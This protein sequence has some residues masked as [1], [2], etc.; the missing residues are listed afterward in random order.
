MAERRW[1]TAALVAMGLVILLLMVALLLRLSLVYETFAVFV[2]KLSSGLG[3]DENL[4]TAIAALTVVPFIYCVGVAFSFRA[5][6]RMLGMFGVAAYVAAYSLAAWFVSQ[7]VYFGPDGALKYYA[8]T[9]EGLYFSDEP[10]VDPV[11][12][13]RLRPVTREVVAASRTGAKPAAL[14]SLDRVEHFFDPSTGEP[15]VWYAKYA[16][17]DVKLFS[18]PGFD[19]KTGLPLLPITPEIIERQRRR[20]AERSRSEAEDRSTAA[21]ENLAKA[22]ARTLQQMVRDIAVDGSRRTVGFALSL[23]DAKAVEGQAPLVCS[24]A[25]R[26]GAPSGVDP[27]HD[28]FAPE[29]IANGY[30]DRVYAGEGELLRDMGATDTTDAIV[31]GSGTAACRRTDFNDVVS[32]DVGISA[33]RFDTEGRLV[34]QASVNAVGPGFSER[35]AI[36]AACTRIVADSDF[37][38]LLKGGQ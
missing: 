27:R 1:G 7:D 18:A 25:V 16:D 6:R 2:E 10:G 22:R 21:A 36:A 23:S 26:K 31:L 38:Q 33:K 14:P 12:G 15:A 32:C 19:P 13:V 11:Y 20:L 9:P 8:A 3:I 28:L 24:R 29:F 35:D 37:V 17:G 30:F 4:A 5:G 34:A